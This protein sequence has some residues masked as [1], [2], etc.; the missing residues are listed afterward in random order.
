[1]RTAWSASR[2]RLRGGDG[3]QAARRSGPTSSDAAEHE[4][5]V[6]SMR[7]A[8]SFS[9]SICRGSSGPSRPGADCRGNRGT[10]PASAHRGRTARGCWRCASG[11]ARVPSRTRAGSPGISRTRT[12]V[13]TLMPNSTGRSWRG[14]IEDE[15]IAMHGVV[16]PRRSPSRFAC[17]LPDQ[18]A[19]QP[20]LVGA[21]KSSRTSDN[22]TAG[23]L[24]ER[25]V[26]GIGE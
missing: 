20:A 21:R 23:L 11:V 22:S 19:C 9:T 15:P 2:P 18:P 10:G 12:K 17:R 5:R 26:A 16:T 6:G 1:M 25:H 13:M 7:L 8:I 4:H 14:R 24:V 3:S